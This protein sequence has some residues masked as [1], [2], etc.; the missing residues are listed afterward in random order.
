MSDQDDV[1][2]VIII[3]GG[4]TGISA[5]REL[6][7]LGVKFKLLDSFT[8]HLGGRAYSYDPG[9]TN[10]VRFDHGAEYIG[11]LQNDIMQLIKEELPPDALVNGANL[12]HPYPYQVMLLAGKKH[13]FRLDQSLFGITGIPPDIGLGAMLG[14][15]GLLAEMTLIEIQIDTWEPWKGPQYL[16]DFD[17]IDVWSWIGSK[18]W[19][20]PTAADLMRISIEALISVEP[21]Q[22]SPYYLFWYTACN[23]GFINEVNDDAGGPQQ[24]WLKGGM[25]E[26][27]E[28]FAKPVIDSIQQGVTVTKIDLSGDV[29]HVTKQTADG[30]T[31]TAKAKKVLVA[32][33][34]STAGK[35]T[36]VPDVPPARRALFD[37]P[38]GKTLKCQV[39]YK[40]SWWHDSGGKNFNGYCGGANNP[41]LWVMDNSPP[42]G[43]DDSV[44]ILMTFTVAAQL[45]KLG[46][47]PTHE[48]I[49]ALVTGAIRD[50]FDDDRAL[51]GSSE[52]IRLVSYTWS[53]SE[54]NVGG[55][56]NTVFTPGALTGAPGQIMDQ[57]WDDKVFFASSE[58]AKNLTPVSKGPKWDLFNDDKLPKY[59][60]DGILKPDPAP[61]YFSNYSDYRQSLGYMDGGI[62][63]GRY[64]AHEIAQ[65]LGVPNSLPAKAAIEGLLHS[66]PSITEDH[67]PEHVATVLEKLKELVEDAGTIA[68]GKW[69]HHALEKALAGD[70]TEDV[71]KRLMKVRDF[72][73][74][75]APHLDSTDDAPPESAGVIAKI[76]SF[77][78][79]I[80]EAIKKK[81][82]L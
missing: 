31:S 14:V 79:D 38:M 36:Y 41:V 3:G 46:P 73:A 70:S 63:S 58:N 53:P 59:T 35:I 1:E 80:E 64:V 49:E 6:Q 22:V 71:V 33:S 39:F 47:N 11:D 67:A 13:V 82:H 40:S 23:S 34:P 21:S 72:A 76:K 74:A 17:K 32:V 66:D 27:A 16:L 57:H 44:H 69:L 68:S 56:P 55:G 25:S 48:Q 37:M 75:A 18:K 29:V 81:L 26:L 4:F 9:H 50:F 30:A 7:K 43:V 5:A 77:G 45:D 60:D 28:K 52:Y 65:S 24:Y 78:K 15:I 8:D 19:V 2:D 10:G 62:I 20:N 51:A 54:K 61:P 12:R 42:P